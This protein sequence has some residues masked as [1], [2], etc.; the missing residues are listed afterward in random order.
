MG[1]KSLVGMRAIDELAR[2][3]ISPLR[4]ILV[5]CLRLFRRYNAAADSREFSRAMGTSINRVLATRIL[6]GSHA[7]LDACGCATS[8]RF[9]AVGLALSAVWYGWQWVSSNISFR[10]MVLR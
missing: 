5:G 4:R 3:G 8:A 1:T 7:S 9:L 10:A 6:R 2:T